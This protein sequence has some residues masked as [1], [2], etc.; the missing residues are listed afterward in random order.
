MPA[1]IDRNTLQRLLEEGAQLMEVL[2]TEEY[3]E[4][5]LPRAINLPLERLDPS[6][7]GVLRLVLQ[8]PLKV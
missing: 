5:H 7:A 4:A 1:A 3:Q 8:F 2:P 6:A